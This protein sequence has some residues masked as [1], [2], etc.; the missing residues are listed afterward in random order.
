MAALGSLSSGTSTNLFGAS[1]KGYTGIA[2][3]LDVDSMIE[4]MTTGTRQKIEKQMSTRQLLSWKQEGYQSVSTKLIDFN[5][6]F[7]SLTASNSLNRASTFAKSIISSQGTNSSK[8]SVSGA[9]AVLSDLKIHGVSQ[10]ASNTVLNAPGKAVLESLKTGELDLGTELQ[11]Q[12]LADSYLEFKYGGK[13]Y[14][15]FFDSS[16]DYSTPEQAVKSINESLMAVETSDGAKLG[17]KMELRYDASSKQYSFVDKQ[18]NKENMISLSGGTKE[19]IKALGMDNVDIKADNNIGATGTLSG[20]TI[21][22]DSLISKPLLRDYLS[23]KEI[24]FSYNGESQS[25]KLPNADD[26]KDHPMTM[27]DLKAS[28]QTSLDKAFGTGKVVV[29]LEAGTGVNGGKLSFQTG[30]ASST[31]KLTGGT[32]GLLGA[33]GALGG[34][35][36]GD[37]NRLNLDATLGHTVLLGSSDP[38]SPVPGASDSYFAIW[39]EA[40]GTQKKEMALEINGVQIHGLTEDSAMRDVIQAINDSDAGVKLSYME[41]ANKFMMTATKGGTAGEITFKSKVETKGGE[42][43]NYASALFGMID[44][45]TGNGNLKAGQ[46]SK[47]TVSYGGSDQLIEVVR[48]DNAYKFEGAT[49]TLNGTF[50]ADSGTE[51]V[52]TFKSKPDTENVTKKVKE[53]VDAYNGLVDD[54]NKRSGTKPNRKYPPLTNEQ[55]TKMSES[56]IRSYED[57]AKEGLLFNDGNLSGIADKL[58]YV[59]SGV[60]NLGTLDDMGLRIASSYTEQGKLTFDEEKF[61]AAMDRDPDQ[62]SRF[63]TGTVGGKGQDGFM[64]RMVGIYDTYAKTDGYAKGTL[65]TLAGSAASATSMINNSIQRQIDGIDENVKTLTKKLQTEIDRYNSQFTQLERLVAQMNSQS[66]ALSSFMQ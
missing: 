66:S 17:E 45:Q 31:F 28:L 46:D 59:F 39:A 61:K 11:L 58:R 62:V 4:K 43:S 44:C 65:I 20:W 30:D 38:T 26:Y 2:S 12:N 16:K 41:T 19:A 5:S 9:S 60:T 63:F 36:T 21:D 33:S 24:Y 48:N 14:T 18:E 47:M 10:L 25:I 49:F 15:A 40:D 32:K 29:D 8:V 50:A 54:V 51:G 1:I 56:E 13:R 34:L 7:L 53:M 22:G 35:M 52:V 64:A 3:G 27:A 57:K 6:K 55:K 23:E 37:G 42:V